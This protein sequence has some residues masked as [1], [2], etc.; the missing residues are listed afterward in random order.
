VANNTLIGA[1]RAEATLESG[2]F[3]DGA[4]KIRQESQKTEAAV[5]SSFSGMGAAIKGFGGAATAGL[6][7]G[8]LTGLAKKAIDYARSIGTVSK[9]LGVTTKDLQTFRYAVTQTGGTVT[10]ADKG[11]EALGLSMSK[12]ASGS[13]PAIAAFSAVGV[14]VE[15]IKTKSKTEIFGQIAEQMT[16]QGGAAKNA[17]AG[18]VIFGEGME[19]LAP[20]LDKGR[21]GMNELS[22][23]AERLGI[24]LSDQQIQNADDT[25]RKLDDVKMVLAAQISGVVADNAQSIVS[26]A[27]AL[28]QL[29]S[30]IINFL[31][32]NPQ[33]ALAII[34]GLTGSRFGV[35]GALGG[36]AIGFF[37]GDRLATSQAN[38]NTDVRFRMEQV[39]KAK[40][41]YEKAKS[42]PSGGAGFGGAG[43]IPISAGSSGNLA[44]AEAELRRQTKLL[45]D[46]T[47]KFK[48]A[49]TGGGTTNPPL[50]QFLA[51]GGGGGGRKA[52]TPRAP[53]DRSDDVAYQFEQELR[54]A[55]MDT[56]RAQQGMTNDFVQR[57]N[58]SR[59]ILDL[60]KEEEDAEIANRV[61]RAERDFAEG[62][63]TEG[64]LQ[65]VKVQAEQLQIENDKKHA[66]EV[67]ALN[68]E[69]EAQRREEVARLSE[70]DFD[71][72]REALELEASMAETAS[73]QRDVQLRL[74]DLWYRQEKA[75]L[76]A[77]MAEEEVGSL[78]WEEARRRRVALD[79]QQGA[80][81]EVVKVGT[82]GPL[83]DY[84]SQLP[85]TTDKWNEALENVAA[86][87]LKSVEDGIVDVLTGAKSVGEALQ[88]ILADI[89]S[90]LIR[91]GVQKLIGTALTSGFAEGGYTGNGGV[92]QVA[93]VVHGRE[94]VINAKATKQ[95][96]PLLEAINSGRVPGMASG[97][98]V[99]RMPLPRT[100][101][102]ARTSVSNDNARMGA[103]FGDIHFS[104][105]GV[106]NARE[107][108]QSGLQAA[109]AFR[110]AVARSSKVNA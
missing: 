12:A 21:G 65:Q 38:A 31:A 49:K 25:A 13:K 74:L 44:S 6:S 7:L 33:A 61:R 109:N 99:G 86:Q 81:R 48:S 15:D 101:M 14:S 32:S 71:N 39:R 18:N 66:L 110:N 10:D 73:E 27:N 22:Q 88:S 87:G 107:A 23:A 46:A 85:T 36:A 63:I 79:A 19:K 11:L 24:V 103:Q 56:L 82:R 50:P 67:Q 83:E 41:A 52:R 102:G 28:G 90:Q 57:T 78:A 97:G 93:G 5:K 64:T 47:S 8:L 45:I 4:K 20:L 94:Y 108:R 80:R 75:K 35:P 3:V 29:T 34:G 51:T 59:Q 62:K 16:K 9:Q 26:L 2:K 104:F 95:Y 58:I 89:I 92:S 70:I 96:L 105:P 1:I 69:E 30:S 84:M 106:T 77:I 54:R 42:T 76:D 68:I 53:R 37:A 98:Y 17:A 100:S 72:Q 55:Q 91:I 40:A 43:G 60:Q